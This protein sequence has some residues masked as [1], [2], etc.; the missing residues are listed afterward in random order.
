MGTSIGK[1]SNT[2]SRPWLDREAAALN[3]IKAKETKRCWLHLEARKVCLVIVSVRSSSPSVV[4]LQYERVLILLHSTR[5]FC[6]D[7]GQ[8]ACH[9]LDPTDLSMRCQIGK[10]RVEQRIAIGDRQRPSSKRLSI[11]DASLMS[12][13]DDSFAMTLRGSRCFLRPDHSSRSTEADSSPKAFSRAERSR[14][15]AQGRV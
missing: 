8:I 14:V 2:S 6:I 5:L 1:T 13:C 12:R 4:A 11:P 3:Q 9:S 10:R 15:G 7:A